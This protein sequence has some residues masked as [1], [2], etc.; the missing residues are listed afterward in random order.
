MT[1]TFFSGLLVVVLLIVGLNLAGFTPGQSKA[2]PSDPDAVEDFIGKWLT[3]DNG[4]LATYIKPG[5]QED[6]DL[7]QGREALTETLGLW[8]IYALEKE[9]QALFNQAYDQLHMYFLEKDGFV[10]WKIA[11]EGNS[12]VSANA[13][14]D[15][16]R[17]SHAL[18]LAGEKWN[19]Q[20]YTETAREINTYLND[21]NIHQG[22]FTDFY[23]QQDDYASN[24][25]TLSYIDGEA[26]DLLASEGN[27]DREAAE[28][29]KKILTEAPMKNGFYPKR[30]DVVAKKYHYD[31]KVNMV[32]QAIMAYH[33]AKMGN[34]SE[35]LLAFIKEEMK[36]R[37]IVHGMYDSKTKAP[38]VDYESP[39]VYGFIILYCLEIK[40]EALTEDIYQEMK[41]F[42]VA[43]KS[44]PYYGG[45]GVYNEDTHIF[46]NLI[47]LLAETKMKNP[48]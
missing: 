6:E 12:E 3:N 25:I 46:D 27:L 37:G 32:D 44:N 34:R 26:L 24:F 42:Q 11:E 4:T 23:E 40:E 19:E 9:D 41:K 36:K 16:I 29:T 21:H 13:L 45:Y 38:V 1:F 47:P 39:A 31:T 30:Y 2:P 14:I 8:M 43:N 35:P 20:R 18:L 7:V 10:N 17:I 28:N 5:D 33:H 48:Q 22:I 15:D